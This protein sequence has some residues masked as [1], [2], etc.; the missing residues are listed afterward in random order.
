MIVCRDCGKKNL[1][2]VY[3]KKCGGDLYARPRRPERRVGI[4]NGS[5]VLR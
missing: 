5:L 4:L 3:C 2:Y 1:A